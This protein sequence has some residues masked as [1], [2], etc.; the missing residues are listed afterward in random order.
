MS[1]LDRPHQRYNAEQLAEL[2]KIAHHARHFV[3]RSCGGERCSCGAAATHKI[4][5]EIPSDEPRERD[6]IDG[7]QF[8][9]ER[10]NFTA[11]VCC[12]CFRRIMGP[13]VFCVD[14]GSIASVPAQRTGD[15]VL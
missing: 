14:S 7:L 3:S 8:V 6:W 12:A 10:H 13:A 2:R 11:Y 1:D 4:G 9:R 15:E 5:E